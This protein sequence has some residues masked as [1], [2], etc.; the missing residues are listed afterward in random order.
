MPVFWG[1]LPL[2]FHNS[3]THCE[4][5]CS[6]AAVHPNLL[7]ASSQ[8]KAGLTWPGGVDDAYGSLLCALLRI[9]KLMA[10][11]PAAKT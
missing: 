4:R 11:A 2:P 3:L 8:Q 10:L 5:L 7:A 9:Q 1:L 6:A